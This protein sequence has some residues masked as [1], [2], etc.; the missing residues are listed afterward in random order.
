[1][2]VLNEKV[3]SPKPPWLVCRDQVHSGVICHSEGH[4]KLH[5][6]VAVCTLY[7]CQNDVLILFKGSGLLIIP[8]L[9]ATEGPF[10][11]KDQD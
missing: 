4:C 9:G 8:R 1:M 3:G 11:W 10:T 5:T 6:D 2:L 7:A